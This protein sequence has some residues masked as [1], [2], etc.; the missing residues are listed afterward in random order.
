M[1]FREDILTI[2]YRIR[3]VKRFKLEL[4]PI[5]LFY[6]Y[7][8]KTLHRCHK[9]NL[10]ASDRLRSPRPDGEYVLSKKE[11]R[12]QFTNSRQLLT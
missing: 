4:E 7:C 2:F 9:L 5:G 11:R 3:E 1:C 12:K 10:G 6:V 8:G